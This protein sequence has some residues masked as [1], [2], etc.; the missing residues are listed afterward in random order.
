MSRDGLSQKV[1]RPIP[2][3]SNSLRYFFFLSERMYDVLYF[4]SSSEL[5]V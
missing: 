2:D 3:T 5:H 1:L 4:V